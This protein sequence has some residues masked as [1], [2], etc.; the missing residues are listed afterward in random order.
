MSQ[1][2]SCL[3]IESSLV[4]IVDSA[5]SYMYIG[6]CI[7]THPLVAASGHAG[8]EEYPLDRVCINFGSSCLKVDDFCCFGSY[9][10]V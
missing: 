7:S 9:F 4:I 2:D 8:S 1:I 10:D 3:G 6:D 5:Y